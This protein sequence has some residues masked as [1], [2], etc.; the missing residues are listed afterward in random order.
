VVFVLIVSVRTI[1]SLILT[2]GRVVVDSTAFAVGCKREWH[3]E[4]IRIRLGVVVGAL[5]S[6][7][8]RRFGFDAGL[9]GLCVF[10]GV[11]DLESHG[12]PHQTLG[13]RECCVV[14]GH[15]ASTSN[16]RGDWLIVSARVGRVLQGVANS[17]HRL[18]DTA[19]SG[20]TSS[21]WNSELARQD[22]GGK[23]LE[24]FITVVDDDGVDQRSAL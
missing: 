9:E 4:G 14:V 17:N 6:F 12:L 10:D 2:H 20:E 13:T 21:W 7:G 1:E 3:L 22:R 15:R 23:F 18:A 19:R 8:T 16:G 5:L 24:F 11:C